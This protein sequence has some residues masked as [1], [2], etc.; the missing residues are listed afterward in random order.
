MAAPSDSPLFPDV[1]T[2]LRAAGCVFAEEEAELLVAAAADAATLDALVRRRAEG[3]PLEYVLGWA[4]FCGLRIEVDPGVFVPRPRTEFLVACAAEAAPGASVI[5]DLCCGSG[6]L[7]VA[8]AARLGAPARA[9]ELCAADLDPAAVRCAARNID[10]FGGQAFQGDLFA[11]L[12]QTL[13]GRVDVLLAN[14]PYVPSDEIPFLPAEARE[15]EARIALDG[16]ADGLSVMRRVAAEARDWLAPG[17]VVLV[18]TSEQQREGAA[19][20][21]VAGGLEAT[22]SSSE[23]FWAT[24][25]LGRR[26]VASAGECTPIRT[27][28]E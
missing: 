11:A 9:L 25:V 27:K 15:H 1:V 17:G 18:E 2:R 12:P 14:T 21:F 24:V 6:A 4:R 3:E 13:R 5:V 19:A 16:G 10:R 7:G 20:A 23:E 28:P 8:L 26:G 22:A